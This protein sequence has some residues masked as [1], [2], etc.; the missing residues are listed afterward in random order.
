MS[1]QEIKEDIVD[2]QEIKFP[3]YSFLFYFC[4]ANCCFFI[5]S[6]V[7]TVDG[8]KLLSGFSP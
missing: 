1:E 2:E 5:D 8:L 6:W 4:I 7:R 3:I